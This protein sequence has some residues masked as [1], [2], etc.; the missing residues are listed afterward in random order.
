MWR[1]DG[2][3][4][5]KVRI[6]SIKLVYH[7]AVPKRKSSGAPGKLRG[8][9]MEK[10]GRL[11]VTLPAEL[12]AILHRQSEKTG[13]AVGA[14]ARAAIE[15][16]LDIDSDDSDS[17]LAAHACIFRMH[18]KAAA[19]MA[20]AAVQMLVRA[21]DKLDQSQ[22]HATTPGVKRRCNR[23]SPTKPARYVSPRRRRM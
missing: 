18:T 3:N 15:R 12:L 16:G 22:E 13:L 9:R 17:D 21:C 11:F 2:P 14:L 7:E 19:T 6:L 1:S 5:L 4:N 8:E 20:R 23:R 10:S